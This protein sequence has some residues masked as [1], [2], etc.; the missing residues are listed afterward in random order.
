MYYQDQKAED[1]IQRTRR[2]FVRQKKCINLHFHIGRVMLW[3]CIKILCGSQLWPGSKDNTLYL[4]SLHSS[5][6]EMS[7][8][9]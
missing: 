9:K 1:L 2:F 7:E 3:F 5:T 6:H 4:S 8:R